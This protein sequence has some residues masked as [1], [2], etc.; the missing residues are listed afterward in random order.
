LIYASNR[1]VFLNLLA[2]AEGIKG[3]LFDAP[4]VAVTGKTGKGK[5][6]LVGL[7][8][9]YSSFMNVQSLFVDPKGE[10]RKWFT[11]LIQDPYYQ[12]HYP[13]FVEHLQKMSYVTLDATNPRN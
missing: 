12:K 3:A 4:H 5:T 7:L 8:F 9:L 2:I 13:L 1:F 10:K 6:F 11:K